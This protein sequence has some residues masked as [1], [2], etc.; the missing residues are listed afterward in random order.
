MMP[1]KRLSLVI[2]TY[3]RCAKLCTTLD[4]LLVQTLPQE[5][6]EVV[7]VNNNSTDDTAARFADYVAAHPQLD[8][9]M[10]LETEQGVSAARN[11]GIAES[12]GEYIVVIDARVPRT[13]LQ[14]FRIASGGGSGRWTD[15]AGIRVGSPSLDVEVHR[16]DDCRNARPR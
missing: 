13:L 7:V 12:R 1:E 16:T 8:A 4:S 14:P 10:V 9:R 3:N 15:T 5:Q 6:W 11:R 2:A